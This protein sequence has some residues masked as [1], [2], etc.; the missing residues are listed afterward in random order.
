MAPALPPPRPRECDVNVID[1]KYRHRHQF[2]LRNNFGAVCMWGL[3]TCGVDTSPP[4]SHRAAGALDP[5]TVPRVNCV[6][7]LSPKARRPSP[8]HVKWT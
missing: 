2:F 6:E 1:K 5:A 3:L 7:L 4:S 8:S